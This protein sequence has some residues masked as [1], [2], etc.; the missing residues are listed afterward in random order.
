MADWVI[1]KNGDWLKHPYLRPARLRPALQRGKEETNSGES[2]TTTAA[3]AHAVDIKRYKWNHPADSRAQEHSAYVALAQPIGAMPIGL[4]ETTT[5]VAIGK[6]NLGPPTDL[7]KDL[8]KC[9]L[10]V[11]ATSGEAELN[12]IIDTGAMLN[13]IHPRF[14]SHLQEEAKVRP[15]LVK[16]IHDERR[17]VDT[18]GI[19]TLDIAGY[20]YVFAFYII[21]HLPMDAIL[22]IDAIAEAAWV[23]D[24][25]ARHLY[26]HNHALP[27]IPL[28]PCRHTASLAYAEEETIISPSTW[29][30]IPI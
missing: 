14:R 16:S 27:P 1:K 7:A 11:Q 17:V 20:P 23:I 3:L 6:Q 30:W 5:S 12:I 24:A 8:C 21:P 18:R 22:G 15:L 28:A 13:F 10:T 29:Q 26:H 19:L 4:G 2:A 25:T 9:L